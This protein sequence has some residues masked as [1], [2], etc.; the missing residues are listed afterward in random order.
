MEVN[1]FYISFL[2]LVLL[3]SQILFYNLSAQDPELLLP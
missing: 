3:E 2:H 1:T